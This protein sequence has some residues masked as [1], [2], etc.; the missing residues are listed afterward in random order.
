[1]KNGTTEVSK[2]LKDTQK[3]ISKFEKRIKRVDRAYDFHRDLD[4][5]K[6]LKYLKKLENVNGLI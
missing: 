6:A 4:Q 5:M 3:T 2:I 1:M